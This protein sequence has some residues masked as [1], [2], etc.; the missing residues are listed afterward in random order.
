[1]TLAEYLLIEDADRLAKATG[2]KAVYLM[3][4][5]SGRRKPSAKLSR[6]IHDATNG[7]V[8]LESLRPDI[9]GGLPNK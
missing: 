5:I 9:W 8:T 7:V 4:I 6:R 2:T 3:Q 1:M